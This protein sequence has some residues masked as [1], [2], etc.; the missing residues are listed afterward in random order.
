MNKNNR[1]LVT[2]RRAKDITAQFQDAASR[3]SSSPGCHFVSPLT[4]GVELQTGELIKDE[5]FTL[6]EAVGALEV[7]PPCISSPYSWL[8]ADSMPL[9]ID[10]GP[11]D[12]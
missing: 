5:W 3:L 7:C 1:G 9:C 2:P 6:F 10:H 8:G 12:G 11:E 4:S